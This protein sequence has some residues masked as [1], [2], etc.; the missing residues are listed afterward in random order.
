MSD[1]CAKNLTPI[2][3]LPLL[4]RISNS[5][6]SCGLIQTVFV[7][8][9][10][11]TR[12]LP[13][14]LKR[15]YRSPTW[16]DMILLNRISSAYQLELKRL[17]RVQPDGTPMPD[18]GESAKSAHSRR[19]E[20]VRKAQRSFTL[21]WSN[22]A[23]SLMIISGNIGKGKRHTSSL[24]SNRFSSFSISKRPRQMRRESRRRRTPCSED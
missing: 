15:P 6:I 1:P 5:I 9:L 3:P 20:Q 24:L 12:E 16:R 4:L 11:P 8:A 17:S 22:P 7:M 23:L 21:P 19:R 10:N 18:K 2:L 13:V 14:H